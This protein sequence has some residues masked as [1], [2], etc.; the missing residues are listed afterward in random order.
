MTLRMKELKTQD[1]T[2]KLLI[3]Y[4]FLPIIA[5]QVLQC[6]HSS[7]Y[8]KFLNLINFLHPQMKNRNQKQIINAYLLDSCQP[9]TESPSSRSTKSYLYSIQFSSVAQS[10]P[11]LCNPM[12]H[13]TP[14]LP[15]HHQLPE[16]TQTHVYLV[17]DAFQP[18]HSLSS[19]SSPAP[20]TSQQLGSFPMSQLFS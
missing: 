13:S 9:D 15:V 1:K 12:N 10:C 11:T 7:Q 5:L 17:G 14:G 3:S 18:S 19:P 16:F 20:N 2:P 8:P 4:L 6:S